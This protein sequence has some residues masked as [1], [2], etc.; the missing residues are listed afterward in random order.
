MRVGRATTIPNQSYVSVPLALPAITH[1]P[2]PFHPAPMVQGKA[3]ISSCILDASVRRIF[4]GNSSEDPV[5]LAENDLLGTAYGLGDDELGEPTL[6]WEEQTPPDHSAP[7][8][9]AMSLELSPRER[10]DLGSLLEE[11]RDV[12]ARGPGDLGRAR[13]VT[14]E[15]QTHGRPIRQP[16]R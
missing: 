12:F 9:P 13:Q 6:P 15:V 4:V 11:Y 10:N 5:D 14:H 8:L 1:G 2:L 3:W 16:F 7:R